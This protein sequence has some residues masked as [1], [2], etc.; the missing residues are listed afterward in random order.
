MVAALQR[1]SASRYEQDRSWFTVN[2]G[3]PVIPNKLNFYGSYY[4]PQ[5]ARD[6]RA[7][8]YGELPEYERVRNEGF[9]KLTFTPTSS[10]LINV[11]Y[12][13]SHRLDTSD[14]FAST[15]SATTGTGNEAWQKI[16]SAEGSWVINSR[17]HFTFRYTDYVNET[18]GRPDN[19]ANVSASTV[20]GTRLDV[21]RLDQIGLLTVPTPVA[22]QAA[23]ND[24]VQPLIDR[25]GYVENGVKVGGGTVGY[26]TTFDEDNF[27][28][29]AGQFGY[30][31]SF[32]GGLR[33]DLHAGYQVLCR[34]RRSHSQLERVGLDHCSRRASELQQ[35]TD[36]L[37]RRLPAAGSRAGADDPFR[38]QVPELRVERHH[39]LEPLD[40]QCRRAREQRHAVRSGPAGRRVEAADRVRR[41]AGGQVRDVRHPVQQDD[42]AAAGGDLGLQR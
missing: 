38:I 10:V 21:N 6:N 3:G 26:G 34:C 12:R 14:L 23:F 42:P 8:K 4:R 29:D 7:N 27:F 35:H 36:L 22:G 39:P 40:V 18:Q 24:F 9:G 13:D 1:T 17:S 19:I 32:G 31:V 16:I 41:Q 20:V 11:S 25:Y 28:R 15:A 33:H 2:A 30:N 5:N 37:H